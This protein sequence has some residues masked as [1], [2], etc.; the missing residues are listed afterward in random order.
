MAFCS[1]IQNINKNRVV[2][3]CFDTNSID[4]MVDLFNNSSQNKIN[5]SLSHKEKL[6]LLEFYL[7]DQAP[8]CEEWCLL[9]A[10]ALKPLKKKFEE[11]FR[12]IVPKKWNDNKRTWLNTLDIE[13]E[14][15][16]YTNAYPEFEFLSV[17]PIDFDLRIRRGFSE[18]CVDQNLCSLNIRDKFTSGK[19]YI[20]AVFNLDRHNQSGS[21]WTAFFV[22]L[23]LGESYYYDSVANFLPK[24]VVE[25]INRISKQGNE[26]IEKGEMWLDNTKTRFKNIFKKLDEN[27][28]SISITDLCHYLLIKDHFMLYRFASILN[29]KPFAFE[30]K[31]NDELIKLI[32]NK[33]LELIDKTNDNRYVKIPD[34]SKI[35][36]SVENRNIKVDD[37]AEKWVNNQLNIALNNFILSIRLLMD[38]EDTFYH[39]VKY[40]VIEDNVIF[41]LNKPLNKDSCRLTDMSFKMFKNY[42]QHQFK[43]TECGMYSINF[44]DSFLT[45]NKTFHQIIQDAIHDDDMNKLRYSK[46]YRPR[47]KKNKE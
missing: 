25:L 44:I 20:A 3:S 1:P 23:K 33:T 29:E 28:V 27:N 38:E 39:I 43:N 13:A 2:N 18:E 16:L 35:I 34:L 46:Y 8:C 31:R 24:E 26:L 45:Q 9:E 32:F 36:N 17:S 6:K 37:F 15:R 22:S 7:K 12:P 42:V 41:E 10:E 5:I 21:H 40:N 30:M 11:Y 19:K 47:S 14:M 4:E